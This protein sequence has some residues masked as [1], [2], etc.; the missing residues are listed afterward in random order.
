MSKLYRLGTKNKNKNF[1]RM[2]T[3]H[4]FHGLKS[5]FDIFRRTKNL[6]NHFINNSDLNS[7]III[8]MFVH[9]YLCASKVFEQRLDKC[10]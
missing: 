4:F 1:V 6:F 7:H 9:R 5:K 2:K 3:S 8:V 10:M